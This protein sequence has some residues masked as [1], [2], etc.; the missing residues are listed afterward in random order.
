MNMRGFVG[1]TTILSVLAVSALV[2]GGVYLFTLTG[3]KQSSAP[4]G[5]SESTS[6]TAQEYGVPDE[7]APLTGAEMHP[8]YIQRGDKI[9]FTSETALTK[10]AAKADCIQRVSLYTDRGSSSCTWDLPG[11]FEPG[12]PLY[13]VKS[14]G[15]DLALRNATISFPSRARNDMQ[16]V[17]FEVT[18]VGGQNNGLS[19]PEF[20]FEVSLEYADADSYTPLGSP[21]SGVRVVPL[22]GEVV[23]VEID[24]PASVANPISGQLYP[25][26]R[27]VIQV[28]GL[29]SIDEQDAGGVNEIKSPT[30]TI[31]E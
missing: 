12:I 2:L 10:E 17:R 9:V 29:R 16:H 7:P 14:T 30:W 4:H 24:V 28:N 5:V 1:V 20:D 22:P 18:N 8:Y 27:A 6:F 23:V 11:S 25:H 19:K 31:S 3:D 26:Y 21:V 13:A 15:A